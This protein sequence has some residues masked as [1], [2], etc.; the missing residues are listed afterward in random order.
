MGIGQQG[1]ERKGGG[2]VRGKREREKRSPLTLLVLNSWGNRL[3]VPP[4]LTCAHGRRSFIIVY[5]LHISGR[6]VTVW[7]RAVS[8]RLAARLSGSPHPHAAHHTRCVSGRD[9]IHRP[10]RN[11]ISDGRLL[12][13]QCRWHRNTARSAN[14]G[15]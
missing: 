12:R 11:T 7:S 15:K 5:E 13:R 10:V 2:E 14:R 8:R 1:I 4:D 3:S 9:E 6:T